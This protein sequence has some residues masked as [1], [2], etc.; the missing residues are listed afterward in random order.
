MTANTRTTAAHMPETT[1]TCTSTA[2]ISKTSNG[3]TAAAH[4][5]KIENTRT[6]TAHIPTR[7]GP[8]EHVTLKPPRPR[9]PDTPKWH[10]QAVLDKGPGWGQG[11]V[12]TIT[13]HA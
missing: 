4:I 2:H 8:A 11:P 1:N 3:R 7:N 6:V 9:P 12:L 10:L 5:P 13:N